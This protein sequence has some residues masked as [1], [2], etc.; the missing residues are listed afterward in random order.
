MATFTKLQTNK[1]FSRF[2]RQFIFLG[3][4]VAIGC[5]IFNAL[6]FFLGSFLGAITLYVVLR[7]LL[8]RLVDNYPKCK[9][10]FIALCLVIAMMVILL[11]IGYMV[12][13]ITANQ[14]PTVDTSR[15]TVWFNKMVRQVNYVFGFKVLSQNILSQSSDVAT[16]V[17]QALFNTTY[18]FAVNIFLMLIILYFMLSKGQKMEKVILQYQPFKGKSLEMVKSEVKNM[19]FSNVVCIPIIIFSQAITAW[20]IFSLFGLDNA[21]FWAFLTALCGLIPV[22]GSALVTIPLGIFIITSGHVWQGLAFIAC[23][24]LIIANVDNVVRIVILK[25]KADTHPLIVIFGVILGIPMFGFWGI[26]FGP[27]LISGFLLLIKIYYHEYGLIKKAD[28]I[29]EV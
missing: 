21:S 14:F 13:E 11:G 25:Q 18:S 8:F 2:F 4:L 10:W 27:L 6:A 17:I 29:D 16:K 15:I 5:M 26:I 1:I 12:F 28:Y 19:I 7:N 3:A 20:G 23:A 9:Q 24:L 22:M